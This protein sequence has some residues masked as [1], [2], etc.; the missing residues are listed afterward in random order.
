MAGT[1][2][3]KLQLDKCYCGRRKKD[4]S[5]LDCNLFECGRWKKCMSKTNS[6]INRDLKKNK[7]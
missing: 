7:K 5:L 6:D 3:K 4:I 2:I 1:T